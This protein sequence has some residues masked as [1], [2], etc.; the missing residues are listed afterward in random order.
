[1]S[2]FRFFSCF[3]GCVFAYR[4]LSL[5]SISV[6]LSCCL[7]L[8]CCVSLALALP[9]CLVSV[10]VSLS[11]SFSLS[12]SLTLRGYEDTDSPTSC[13]TSWKIVAMQHTYT[14]H[15]YKQHTSAYVS[16]RQHAFRT[17]CGGF[18][19]DFGE[20]C[21]DVALLGDEGVFWKQRGHTSAAYV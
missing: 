13:C 12:L 10:S 19:G 7:S 20:V 21:S 4:A 18:A 15:T 11:A 8:A 5:L 3:L 6:C 16:I 17:S 9:V 1:V 2:T 14:Q